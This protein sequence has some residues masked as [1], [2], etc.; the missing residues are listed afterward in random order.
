MTLWAM[1]PS[2]GRIR[3]RILFQTI[4]SERYVNILNEIV[5]PQLKSM[6]YI[7]HHY[8]QDGASVHSSRV[9]RNLLNNE[10][11]NHW[12]GRAGPISWPPR[13]PD[14]SINDFWLWSYL[15]CKVYQD[16]LVLGVNRVFQEMEHEMVS[17]C[18]QNFIKRC[19]KCIAQNGGHFEQYL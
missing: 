17:N 10:L 8:Q 13:S 14:L 16:E 1:I 2:D 4:K 19:E 11:S 5:V 15:R 6:R 9:V 18:F 12:I 3:H 7:H